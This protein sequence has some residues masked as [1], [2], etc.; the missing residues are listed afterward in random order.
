[1]ALD[2]PADRGTQ[3][4]QVARYNPLEAE[5]AFDALRAVRLAAVNDPKL[6]DNPYFQALVDTASA[7][8]TARFVVPE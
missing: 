4:I 6:F 8:F 2:N 7:R 1:M 5:L 3:P